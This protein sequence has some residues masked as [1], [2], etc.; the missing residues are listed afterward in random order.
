M[1]AM[2]PE[3]RRAPRKRA[4]TRMEVTD[5]VACRPIGQLGNL[6]RSGLLLI[7]PQP[8]REGAIYQLRVDLPSPDTSRHAHAIEIGAQALW[9]KPTTGSDQSWA[10]YRIIAIGDTDADTLGTWLA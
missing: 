4:D 8:P 9:H 7:T 2:S 10:G 6:S 1:H 3:Q 5:V